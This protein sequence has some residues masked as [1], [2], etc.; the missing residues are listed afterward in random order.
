MKSK[1]IKIYQDASHAWAKIDRQDLIDLK[2]VQDISGYS[3]QRKGCVYLEEDNDLGLYINALRER[4]KGIQISY[5]ISNSEISKI[6]KYTP[7]HMNSTEKD[8]QDMNVRIRS[9]IDR[10][11]R[12]FDVN[13][14][15]NELIVYALK[16]YLE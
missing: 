10:F 8:N 4:F 13:N 11:E 5:N 15:D 2:I 1:V 9:C 6:R 7:F 3:Y 16:K 12:G 14:S